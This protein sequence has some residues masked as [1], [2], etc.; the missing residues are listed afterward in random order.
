MD[1]EQQIRLQAY[2]I[3]LAAG[4]GEGDAE[5]HWLQAEMALTR[6]SVPAS[7]SAAAKSKV[8]KSASTKSAVVKKPA[9]KAEAASLNAAKPAK[10]VA[11]RRAKAAAV[12]GGAEASA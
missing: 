10:A 5:R 4:M 3:W 12:Q 6:K 2:E 7:K 8:A 1:I 11:P 9:T